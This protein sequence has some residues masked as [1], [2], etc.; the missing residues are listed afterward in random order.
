MEDKTNFFNIRPIDNCIGVYTGQFTI[1]IRTDPPN[2]KTITTG[3]K[4]NPLFLGLINPQSTDIYIP[5]SSSYVIQDYTGAPDQMAIECKAQDGDLVLESVTN[6]LFPQDMNYFIYAFAQK[7]QGKV[8]LPLSV[9]AA[10]QKEYFIS[11]SNYRKIAFDEIV[12][13]TVGA[14]TGPLNPATVTLFEFTH[15]L[16]Y[17][18]RFLMFIEHNGVLMDAANWSY[19]AGP[20]M[21]LATTRIIRTGTNVIQM[22]ILNSVA[23]DL[24]IS[25]HVRVYYD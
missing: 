25:V 24:S 20:G 10:L 7:N 22:I 23:S 19:S 18:P 17:R 12:P 13:Y 8:D 21:G 4:K 3:F 2:T 15:G 14:G 9:P 16:G 11:T 1:P 6:A 5:L